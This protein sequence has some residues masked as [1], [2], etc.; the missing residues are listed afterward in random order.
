MDKISKLNTH[1]EKVPLFMQ[2]RWTIQ[3]EPDK[4]IPGMTL[5]HTSELFMG[6]DKWAKLSL[7][8]S[9]MA[10]KQLGEQAV[11]HIENKT[12]RAEY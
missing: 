7:K 10:T 11:A 9:D 12:G 2:R 8:Y 5:R 1:T 6:K 4:L 3:G